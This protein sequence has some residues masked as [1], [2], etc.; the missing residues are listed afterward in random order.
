[1]V[2]EDGLH[3]VL[4]SELFLFEALLFEVLFGSQAALFGEAMQELLVF[5]MLAVE[6]LISFVMG[7][8]RREVVTFHSQTLLS[9]GIRQRR[10]SRTR[11]S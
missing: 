7:Q 8:F 10:E 6:I 4:E 9:M 1:M 2:A 3:F 5:L 11:R